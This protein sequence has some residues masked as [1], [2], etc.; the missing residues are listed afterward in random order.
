MTG[1]AASLLAL[2]AQAPSANA[3]DVSAEARFDQAKAL[4]DQGRFDDAAEIFR[5]LHESTGKPVLLS[6]IAQSLRL[7]GRCA[8]A[9]VAYQRFVDA[10]AELKQK[11]SAADAGSGMKR[12]I[13]DLQLAHGRIVEMRICA[14]RNQSEPARQAAFRRLAGG[15]QAEALQVLQ[16]IW[17]DGHDPTLLAEIAEI[18]R[19]Q[20]HCDEAG[21]LLNLAIVELAPI[22]VLGTE[23]QGRDAAVAIEALRRARMAKLDFR[24]T[25]ASPPA[26]PPPG[27]DSGPVTVSQALVSR[28]GPSEV[29]LEHRA[30]PWSR[31]GEWRRGP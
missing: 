18:H 10:E 3:A 22:E 29:K 1:L 8:A 31:P 20:G 26:P 9:L 14:S 16:Q 5:Q 28:T 19:G 30:A 7:A 15:E 25:S 2:L 13:T 21:R 17:E 27:A 11:A 23:S 12:V 4:Y 24:C 6:S